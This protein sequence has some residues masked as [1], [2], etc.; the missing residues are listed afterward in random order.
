MIAAAAGCTVVFGQGRKL[1]LEIRVLGGV[2]ALVDGQPL[3]LGGSKQRAVLAILA[4]HANRIVSTEDLIDG[5]WGERPP[6]SAAKNVQVYI[7]RLRKVLPGDSGAE[8]VTRGRGY[9]LHLAPDLLDAA[10]FERLIEQ[11]S[12]EAEHDE[13]DGTAHAALALWG[14]AP[15]ADVAEEPFAARRSDGSR[16]CT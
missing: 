14:G 8:I 4:L 15:L 11:A 1:A 13:M 3:P 7:S 12:R 9:A 10:R 5:L 2:D 16:N 6:T